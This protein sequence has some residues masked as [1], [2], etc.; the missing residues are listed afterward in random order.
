[1]RKVLLP[2]WSHDGA[3]L[4]TEQQLSALMN[5]SRRRVSDEKAPV[6]KQAVLLLECALN[7]A[8]GYA[9]GTEVQH[10]K[11]IHPVL[12]AWLPLLPCTIPFFKD[13]TYRGVLCPRTIKLN[14]PFRF[15]L[16][17]RTS[18]SVVKMLEVVS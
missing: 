13:Y 3:S 6:R 17:V 14:L 4:D 1:M 12:G 16:A 11:S 15:I 18:P 2:T 9:R 8:M 7:A 5:V 10:F